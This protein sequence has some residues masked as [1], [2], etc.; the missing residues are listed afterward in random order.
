MAIARFLVG[1]GEASPD[2]PS[3]DR[4]PFRDLAQRFLSMEGVGELYRRVQRPVDRCL[5]ENRL[6]EMKVDY[7][8]TACDRSRIPAAGDLETDSKSI[9]ILLKQDSRWGGRLACFRVDR[10]FSEVLA[11]RVLADLPRADP[12]ALERYM[13][14]DGV[15]GFQQYHGW[16]V[17]AG[18]A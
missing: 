12:K 14:K 7:H 15:E 3:P 2:T 5:L 4:L 13:G 6:A 17:P 10:S 16:H 8:V 9:P 18:V 1:M 11:G